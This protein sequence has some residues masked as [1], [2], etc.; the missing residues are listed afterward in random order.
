[1]GILVANAKGGSG[2]TPTAIIVAGVLA[3]IRDGPVAVA[4]FTQAPGT[5]CRRSEGEPSTEL[6]EI[7]TGAEKTTAAR[8]T[9]GS[10]DSQ[11]CLAHVFGSARGRPELRGEDVYAAR[12]LLDRHYHLTVIDTGTNHLSGCY[13]AIVRACDAVVVPVPVTPDGLDGALGTIDQ[14]RQYTGQHTGLHQRVTAVINHAGG[15]ELEEFRRALPARLAEVCAHVVEV[16]EDPEV[17]CGGP[18]AIS[19]LSLRSL[20]KWTEVA[21]HVVGDLTAAPEAP[22]L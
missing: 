6:A 10:T 16:P 11:T 22:L 13:Q 1:M 2:K 8:V 21:A 9:S 19:R 5:L 18:I 15:S 12:R 14:I 7:L 3:M 20:R 17:G 4:E